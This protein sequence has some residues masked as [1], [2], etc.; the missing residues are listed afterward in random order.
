MRKSDQFS[1][2]LL[3]LPPTDMR[4]QVLSL[5]ELVEG[6]MQENPFDGCLFLFCNRRRDI[7]KGI[8]FDR[9]GFCLWMKK[10]DQEKFPW[11]RKGIGSYSMSAKDLDLLL[12]GVD[13]FSRH[14]K[15]NFNSMG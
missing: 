10:L 4:K 2:I 13:V 12:D 15:L 9:A 8:Y 1:R 5:A 14:K 11:V 3:F 7:I 6:S